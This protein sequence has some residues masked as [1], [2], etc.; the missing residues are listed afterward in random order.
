MTTPQRRRPAGFT[1][2]AA[3]TAPTRRPD[4]DPA[5]APVD[6]VVALP[7][8]HAGQVYV[9]AG[10]SVF[11]DHRCSKVEAA[12]AAD[13]TIAVVPATPAGYADRTLCATCRKLGAAA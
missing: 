5:P 6:D 11:H 7:Q 2:P 9:V 4:P 1:W 10:S 8:L 13:K 12:F 3:P